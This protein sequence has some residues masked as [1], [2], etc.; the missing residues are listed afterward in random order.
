MPGILP[1]RLCWRRKRV[2][3]GLKLFKQLS[4]PPAQFGSSLVPGTIAFCLL[5]NPTIQEGD[6]FAQE[7]IKLE[8]IIGIGFSLQKEVKQAISGK[9]HK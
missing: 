4:P 8:E 7:L 2:L 1:S 3:R 6:G 5:Y 9:A